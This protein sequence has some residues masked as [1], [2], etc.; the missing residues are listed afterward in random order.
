MHYNKVDAYFSIHNLLFIIT[1]FDTKVQIDGALKKQ[2]PEVERI[3]SRALVSKS[4]EDLDY[5][6]F[7]ADRCGFKEAHPDLYQEARS[8]FN[9]LKAGQ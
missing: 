3:L 6:L 7:L 1:D 8:L 4:K 5:G 9:R 2:I